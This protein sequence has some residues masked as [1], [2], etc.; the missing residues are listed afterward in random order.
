MIWM[1]CW[2][3]ERV[4]TIFFACSVSWNGWC[5]HRRRL[6]GWSRPAHKPPR[7]RLVW[8][9]ITNPA[10]CRSTVMLRYEERQ[11]GSKNCTWDN[12]NSSI[13]KQQVDFSWN[14]YADG[15]F[16]FYDHYLIE[17]IKSKKE[18]E[19]QEFFLL[20]AICHTVMVDVS[21]GKY[22]FFFFCSWKQ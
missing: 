2:P 15:K 4:V 22:I 1:Y 14:M 12:T 11:V 3:C 18:P 6:S 16:L 20:L 7:G 9:S 19:I 17:Q 8:S 5:L 21:N 13:S 10:V